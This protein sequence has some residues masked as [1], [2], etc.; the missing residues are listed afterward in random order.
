[1]FM[2]LIY[3][4]AIVILSGC[5]AAS[6]RPVQ[7]VTFPQ[8]TSGACDKGGRQVMVSGQVSKAYQDTIVTF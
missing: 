1:M 7:E 4:T 2:R 8:F 3:T 5:A 6:Y